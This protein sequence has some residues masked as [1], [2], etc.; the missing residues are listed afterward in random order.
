MLS[1]SLSHVL[2]LRTHTW[3][4]AVG[5]SSYVEAIHR[6]YIACSDGVT[7]GSNITTKF[8][9]LFASTKKCLTLVGLDG[10]G[11]VPEPISEVEQYET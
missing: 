8:L 10:A 7:P 11:D 5:F 4:G 2:L 1:S 6:L 9:F 3:M